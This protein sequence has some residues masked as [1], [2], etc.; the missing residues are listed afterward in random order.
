MDP[1]NFLHAWD[2]KGKKVEMTCG[3]TNCV[4]AGAY[5]IT[6]RRDGFIVLG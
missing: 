2:V 6:F 1:I 3:E 5:G 4:V